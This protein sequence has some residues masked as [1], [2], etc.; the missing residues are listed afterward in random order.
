MSF[1][2]ALLALNL[3][4]S[5][6]APLGVQ[7]HIRLTAPISS[8]GSRAGDPISAVLIAPVVFSTPTADAARAPGD[9]VLLPAGSLISGTLK[10]VQRVG[11]GIVHENAALDLEFNRV[12]LANGE[13]LPLS[14]RVQ[15][16]DTGRERVARDGS[17]RGVRPTGS[18]SYRAG[19]YIR[20]ALQSEIHAAL[21]V[22]AIRTL[23]VQVPEPELYYPAGVELTLS[24]IQP[25]YAP[26]AEAPVAVEPWSSQDRARMDAVVAAMP[27][28]THTFNLNRP[29]RN[30]PADLTNLLFLGSREDLTAAFEAAGWIPPDSA[31]LRTNIRRIRAV[32]DG[33]GD[34]AAP[35]S[36][37]LV[38]DSK[39]DMAWQKG[40]NDVSKRHHIRIWK[41]P[42]TWQGRE[43]WIAAATRDVDFAY[44]RPGRAMTH[45]IDENIDEE[46]DK[47]VNDLL[48]TNCVDLVDWS[49]RTDVPTVSRNATGDPMRTDARLAIVGLRECSAPRSMSQGETPAR[50]P[51]GSGLQRFARR[52][53][54]SLRND[55]L[56][57]NIY[58]RS[59]EG[60]RWVVATIR[61]RR[62]RTQDVPPAYPST[63]ELGLSSSRS[64]AFRDM[65][66]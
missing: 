26:R 21:A 29:A 42:E 28:R 57:E 66:E 37:L 40:F 35:M 51:R 31:N 36:T 19:G 18:L 2:Y 54:L 32:A 25:L 17:I 13:R 65:L 64:R 27:L 61:G 59:Y 46:R 55:L 43:T 53:I 38:E 47:V 7:L 63:Y 6:Q 12:T 22:W 39:P 45:K 5:R 33:R 44:L 52:E 14:A 58:W 3:I 62:E 49:E 15:E 60:I 9:Q 11:L 56:R 20:T 34:N 8:Y 24:L 4:A 1:A 30:R 41:Q 48:F 50:R 16:V 10:S 23:L